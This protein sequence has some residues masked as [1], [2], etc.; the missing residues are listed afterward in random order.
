ML[1]CLHNQKEWFAAM[2]SNIRHGLNQGYMP[3]TCHFQDTWELDKVS[4]DNTNAEDVSLA[5]DSPEFY[6]AVIHVLLMDTESMLSSRN[7]LESQDNYISSSLQHPH[8]C[9]IS[10]MNYTLYSNKI[11]NFNIINQWQLQYNGGK[12]GCNH[13]NSEFPLLPSFPVCL[14]LIQLLHVWLNSLVILIEDITHVIIN[15]QSA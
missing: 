14:L 5:G 11:N 12:V 6:P 3:R 4:H 9:T 8:V 10:S 7:P 1:E 15:L 2:E 13:G